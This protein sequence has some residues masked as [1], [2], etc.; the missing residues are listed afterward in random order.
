MGVT[1]CL[2]V[3]AR[4]L[5]VRGTTALVDSRGRRRE[6]DASFVTP[7]VGDYVLVQSDVVMRILDPRDAIEALQAWAEVE[8]PSSA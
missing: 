2:T 3:P 7:A 4:V 5:E 6:V 8:E 1:M